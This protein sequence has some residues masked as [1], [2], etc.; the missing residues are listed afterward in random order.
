MKHF[1]VVVIVEAEDTLEA[2]E[3]A[4]DVFANMEAAHQMAATGEIRVRPARG[5]ELPA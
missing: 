3:A 1:A 4:G 2:V 5:D